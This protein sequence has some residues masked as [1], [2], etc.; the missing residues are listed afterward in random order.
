[1]SKRSSF[2]KIPKD[3]Y[4]TTDPKAIPPNLVKFIRGMTYAEP[5]YGE[6]DLEDLLMDVAVCRW[7]SDIRDTGCCKLWDAT[8]LSEHELG[9]CDVI[10]TNPPFS[11]SVLLPMIDHFTSLK[12]TWLLLPA[13]YMHNR[14]FAPYMRKCSLV[15]SIGRL[16]WFKDSKHTST[17]DFAWYYFPK[18]GS[19]VPNASTF[20][21]RGD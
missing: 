7:R 3:F 15:V 19:V 6:G 21:T 13:G 9:H 12:P 16:K 4:A 11:R 1:M 18:D 17:D 5:C 8:C 2:E 14:Y 20:M 10:I